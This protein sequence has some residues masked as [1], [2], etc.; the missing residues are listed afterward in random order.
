MRAEALARP[1]VRPTNWNWKAVAQPAGRRR[2]HSP[3][4]DGKLLRPSGRPAV[5]T[6]GVPRSH[7]HSRPSWPAVKP[8]PLT[9]SPP[10]ETKMDAAAGEMSRALA[11]VPPV[12]TKFVPTP[13]HS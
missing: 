12:W 10:G 8:D 13:S 2:R 6:P 9:W 3:L 11:V 1:L 7:G 5:T 4:V